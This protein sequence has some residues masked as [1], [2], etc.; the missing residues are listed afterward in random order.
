M[1]APAR[2]LAGKWIGNGPQG[3]RYRDNVVNPACEYEA[4][5][6]LDLT[7][8]SNDL[9]GN[10]RFTV[11]KVNQLLKSVPCLAKKGD[12]FNLPVSGTAV[13]AQIQF[14]HS[15]ISGS[16]SPTKFITGKFT[17]DIMSGT[18]ERAPYPSGGD[19]AGLKGE[20]I[21]SRGEWIVSRSR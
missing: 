9:T 2:G 5:L 11:R 12:S 21:V 13:G 1:V 3:A 19:L 18:F 15:G 6:V 20:W 10:I 4:D 17:N 7:Q 14:S 16:F 8:K